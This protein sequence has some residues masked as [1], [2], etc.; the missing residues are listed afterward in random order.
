MINV[1]WSTLNKIESQ[2]ETNGE[3]KAE[4]LNVYVTQHP[5]PTWENVSDALYRMEDEECH[6]TLDLL[7][8][9]F[10]TGES[11]S[12]FPLSIESLRSPYND[13][14]AGYHN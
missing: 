14:S 9:R 2:F 7:Q 4:L 8:S 10:P 13:L 3:R 5:E 1:P 6:K 12:L 11:P